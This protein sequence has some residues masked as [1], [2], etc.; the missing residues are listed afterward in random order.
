MPIG[1]EARHKRES[2]NSSEGQTSFTAEPH[3]E[4]SKGGDLSADCK[5][6]GIL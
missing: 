5:Y 2:T 6:L 1:R 4:D 3:Q